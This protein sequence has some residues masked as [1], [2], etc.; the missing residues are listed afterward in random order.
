MSNINLEDELL[1]SAWEEDSI[2][3]LLLNADEYWHI[4]REEVMSELYRLSRGGL[5]AAYQA[6]GDDPDQYKDV[7][8]ES[9]KLV[10]IDSL[11]DVFLIRT[12][13]TQARSQEIVDEQAK[14]GQQHRPGQPGLFNA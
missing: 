10:D 4:P 14:Q 8:I 1:E 13:K 9:L 6:C 5:I 12:D 7:D 11:P 2:L 3:S